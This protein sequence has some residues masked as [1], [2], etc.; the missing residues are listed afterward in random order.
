MWR[1]FCFPRFFTCTKRNYI[2]WNI[3]GR[4]SRLH[5]TMYMICFSLVHCY[6]SL[7]YLQPEQESKNKMGES[8]SCR[9]P[10]L[11]LLWEEL[12]T[13]NE[14]LDE[15]CILHISQWLGWCNMGNY[16]QAAKNLSSKI[17]TAQ[18]RFTL[19]LWFIAKQQPSLHTKATTKSKETLSCI[20][21]SFQLYV[22]ELQLYKLEKGK[23][24]LY[25]NEN[26]EI[27]SSNANFMGK[28]I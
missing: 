5:G 17:D 3:L 11:E 16:T 19:G 20:W 26:K 23:I 6:Q 24:N 8:V 25:L 13:W 2:P 1:E 12:F 10:L 21:M 22:H 7:N 4:L 28:S 9:E 15:L 27:R 14:S 18:L